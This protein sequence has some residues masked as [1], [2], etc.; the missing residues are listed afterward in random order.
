V[1]QTSGG[2]LRRCSE[3]AGKGTDFPT[4]WHEIIRRHRLVL[5]PPEQWLDGDRTLLRI[6]LATGQWLT[7]DSATKTFSL[8]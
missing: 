8:G 4:I 3:A 1:E 2:L 6:R 5:G 7:F